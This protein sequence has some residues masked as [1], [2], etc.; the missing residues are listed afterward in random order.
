MVDITCPIPD[1]GFS[2][3]VVSNAVG[4]A[5]LNTHALLNSGGGAA[6]P[7]RNVPKLEKP[8]VECGISQEEWNMFERR[9][10]LYRDCSGFTE[11]Q[12]LV[13]LHQCAN[14]VLGDAMLKV[15]PSMMSKLFVEVLSLM[16]SLAVNPSCNWCPTCRTF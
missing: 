10:Q 5:L 14:P 15:D 6:P 4:I 9:W 1:C 8:R 2:T 7:R 13:C 12:A 3:G 11:T 16:K